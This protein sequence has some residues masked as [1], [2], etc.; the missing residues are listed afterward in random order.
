MKVKTK[1]ELIVELVQ[2]HANVALLEQKVRRYEIDHL[3]LQESEQRYQ[4]VFDNSGAATFIKE[5]DMTISMVN[6]EFERLT[7]YNKKQIE[8]RMKW[9]DFIHPDDQPRLTQHH[10]DHHRYKSAPN[11]LE[12][13]ITDNGGMVKEV[14]LKL[15]LIPE[16]RQTIGS[17]VDLSQLKQMRHQMQEGQALFQAIVEGFEGFIYVCDADYRL[18]Y[19]NPQC[20]QRV[21]GNAVGEICYKVIHHRDSPCFFCVQD[22]VQ[23]G[24]TVRFEMINPSDQRWYLSTNS[25][26]HH[27]D[28]RIS[29]LALVTDINACKQA[30]AALRAT[31]VETC[32]KNLFLRKHTTQRRRLGNI[33]GK[34]SAMQ[35]VY[36]Q[37]I[38]AAATDATVIIYG[39][40][41]T[42]KELAARAIHDLSNRCEQRFVPVHC[43][44]IPEKL[45][46]SEFFGY[47]KGAFSGADA[48]RNGYFDFAHGGTMFLD[49]IGEIS[50]QM[51]IKLLR[52]IEGMGYTPVGGNRTKQANSRI[53]A[54]T[55]RNLR[56]RIAEGQMR[57]DFYYRVHILPI[58]LPPLK[59]RKEDLPLLIDHFLA[60]FGDKHKPP[61]LTGPM[62]TKLANHDWPG[63]IRELQNVIIRYCSLQILELEDNYTSSR[64]SPSINDPGY[65]ADQGNGLKAL[66]ADHERRLL[67]QALEQHQWRR[68]K[69]A[70]QLKI[71]RKTLFSK[72]KRYGLG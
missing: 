38:N 2:L 17:I 30:K 41:G 15:D 7:G 26:I 53:I 45:I 32:R 44:A 13:R 56:R 37:I 50:L 71:D 54:A 18:A 20:Q 4:T 72:M 46:E 48:D 33:V 1:E 51:Q 12:C 69:V 6:Q 19:L 49:E 47:R 11:E 65:R 16:T 27:V 29:L 28:G 40:A 24:E 10:T 36:E 8:G 66:M 70:R 21:G 35:K 61:P 63:N 3:L 39:E 14:F 68:G 34:S 5:A 60:L 31:E 64:P 23:R 55:N 57:T 59:D 67:K 9:T 43:G 25:P 22:Q 58:H 42:G 62:L 52:V